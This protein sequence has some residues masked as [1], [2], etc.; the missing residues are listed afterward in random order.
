MEN[1]VVE[2]LTEILRLAN[3]SQEKLAQTIGVSFATLN[4][5]INARSIPH[6]KH[7][8]LIEDLYKKYTGQFTISSEELLIKQQKILDF[9]KNENIFEKIVNRK[10]LLDEFILKLTYNSNRIEG[11]TLTEAETAKVIF[12]DIAL[13]NKS[14]REQIEAKNHQAAFMFILKLIKEKQVLN[15]KIILR[16]HEILM[17]GILPEAGFYRNHPVRI[18]GTRVLTANFIKVPFLMENLD[19]E[20][21]SMPQNIIRQITKIHADFEKIHP[22]A[23]GNGRTGRLVMQMMA[24]IN[25][26]PPILIL[27]KNKHFYYTALSKAQIDSDYSL[28]E[29]FIMDTMLETIKII[30]N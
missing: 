29:D 22:F 6:P 23:D 30:Q 7:K 28:L 3:F 16:I 12:T 17:N 27:D 9:C 15:E 8:T 14:L 5:W 2:K 20:L 26:L 4:S 11:S 18:V 13:T 24:L 21:L 10:D 19:K 25:N 1:E